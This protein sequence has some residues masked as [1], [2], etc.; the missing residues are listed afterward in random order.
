[1]SPEVLV[2]T[3]ERPRQGTWNIS[4]LRKSYEGRGLYA[5]P[6]DRHS[7]LRPWELGNADLEGQRW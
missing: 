2:W 3:M 4:G 1:M 6:V 7:G 5:V